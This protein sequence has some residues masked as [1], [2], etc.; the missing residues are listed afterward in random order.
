[1][2]WACSEGLSAELARDLMVGT[3]DGTLATSDCNSSSDNL[4]DDKRGVL[5]S[6]GTSEGI[7]GAVTY[8]EAGAG[9]DNTTDSVEGA[10]EGARAEP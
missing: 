2:F 5:S 7:L 10:L 8:S 1:M 3:R 4:N 9:R 6:E